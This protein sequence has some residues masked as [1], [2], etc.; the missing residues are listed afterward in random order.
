MKSKRQLRF[1]VFLL[2]GLIYFSGGCA[3]YYYQEGRTFHQCA[4]DRADCFSELKK[5]LGSEDQKPGDY[6][7]KYMENCMK[8]KGYELVTEDKLPLDVKREDPDSSLYGFLYGYRRG[9]AGT[10]DEQ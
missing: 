1:R 7:H 4:R 2:L 5:R 3:K 9:I 8:Q 10:L 6:E